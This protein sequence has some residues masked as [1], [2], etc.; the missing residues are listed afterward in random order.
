M[1]DLSLPTAWSLWNISI[2]RHGSSAQQHLPILAVAETI[3]AIPIRVLSGRDVQ[4]KSV[5]ININFK[6]LED[7]SHTTQF[8]WKVLIRPTSH[9]KNCP[10]WSRLEI[11][12]CWNSNGWINGPTYTVNRTFDRFGYN[13][14]DLLLQWL[15]RHILSYAHFRVG[16]NGSPWF[17]PSEKFP[18]KLQSNPWLR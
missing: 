6:H 11:W 3:P 18:Y 15:T 5:L 8:R 13:F 4:S 2:R 9:E 10:Y 7:S 17:E 14:P 1:V 16:V 12:R